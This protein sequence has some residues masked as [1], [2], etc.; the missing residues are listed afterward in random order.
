MARRREH[1][2]GDETHIGFVVDHQDEGHG[3]NL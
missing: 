2:P 3:L 1:H